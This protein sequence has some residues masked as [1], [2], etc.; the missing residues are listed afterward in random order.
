MGRTIMLVSPSAACLPPTSAARGSSPGAPR[1]P[2]RLMAWT[3]GRA[4][5]RNELTG[6]DTTL[7]RNLRAA[8]LR[9]A[10][11]SGRAAARGA[12]TTPTSSPCGP[13]PG[14]CL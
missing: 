6:A 14:H 2:S 1:G 3:S 4:A 10:L 11:T 7:L 5:A 12:R 9:L 13:P 8:V